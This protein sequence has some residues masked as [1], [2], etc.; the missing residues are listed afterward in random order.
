M[1]VDNLAIVVYFPSADLNT[2]HEDNTEF[3][4]DQYVHC[5]YLIKRFYIVSVQIF[6]WLQPRIKILPD[7]LFADKSQSTRDGEL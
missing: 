6:V 7:G 4:L 5:P 3:T 1:S 2:S